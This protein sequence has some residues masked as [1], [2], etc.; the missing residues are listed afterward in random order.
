M[1]FLQVG[2]KGFG[3]GGLGI[4]VQRPTPKSFF[5]YQRIRIIVLVDSTV[6]NFISS[7]LSKKPS[8]KIA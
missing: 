1:F 2:H 5:I 4:G 8:P 7:L 6:N 3:E